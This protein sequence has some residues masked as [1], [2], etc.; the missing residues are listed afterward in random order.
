M[1]LEEILV[2]V[3]KK[4]RETE[5]FFYTKSTKSL[6]SCLSVYNLYGSFS[7]VL[8]KHSLQFLQKCSPVR[9]DSL[10]P[11]ALLHSCVKLIRLLSC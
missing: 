1:C 6:P 2:I 11:S 10:S 5:I 4:K 7:V 3:K 8:E 9:S